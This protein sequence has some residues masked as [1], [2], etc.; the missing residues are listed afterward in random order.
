MSY[1]TEISQGSPGIFSV[2]LQINHEVLDHKRGLSVQSVADSPT[3]GHKVNESIRTGDLGLDKESGGKS[4]GTSEHKVKAEAK[5]IR[6]VCMISLN[7][8]TILRL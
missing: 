4:N 6:K 1:N 2:D 5:S 3:N 8:L 7:F